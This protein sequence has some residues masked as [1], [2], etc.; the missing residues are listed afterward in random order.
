MKWT[1][2][3]ESATS[4]SSSE[5]E[6]LPIL[7][8]SSSDELSTIDES[9]MENDFSSDA[10]TSSSSKYL[11]SLMDRSLTSNSSDDQQD[12]PSRRK[13][14]QEE[15]ISTQQMSHARNADG[16]GVCEHASVTSDCENRSTDSVVSFIYLFHLELF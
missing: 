11:S 7:P 9:H 10:A 3:H 13:Y 6:T 8:D 5:D 12:A 2:C 16:A 15:N 1:I 4:S 14:K